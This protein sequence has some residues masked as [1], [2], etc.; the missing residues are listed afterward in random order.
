[1]DLEG[2]RGAEVD[3]A[4]Q[5]Y[6]DLLAAL[7]QSSKAIIAAVD[8]AVMAGGVG[9]AAA[10]DIV[11]ATEQSE[12]GLAEVML[13]LVPGMV[14]ATLMERMPLGQARR[15]AMRVA[16]IDAREALRIGLFDEVVADDGLERGL[17]TTIKSLLRADPDA[18]A[19]LKRLTRKLAG[20]SFA[21]ALNAGREATAERLAVER[22]R[23]AIESFVA[24]E[25]LPW[26]DRYRP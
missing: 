12:V 3:S 11:I 5:R 23:A 14:L 9:L 25:P 13:G 19:A 22:T 1:M 8:G 6:A 7:R 26:F 2:V 24:G 17:R 18:L 4:L 15:L 20:A 21:D 10:A 16:S